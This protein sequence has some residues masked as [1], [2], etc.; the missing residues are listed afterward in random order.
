MIP[1][2]QGLPSLEY[3]RDPYTTMQALALNGTYHLRTD[4][5]L[6]LI[7]D[8]TM[9]TALINHQALSRPSHSG[10]VDHSPIFREHVVPWLRR[11][12]SSG[13]NVLL[14]EL[15][16]QIMDQRLDLLERKDEV[17]IVS[18]F[19]AWVP[20]ALMCNLLGLLDVDV[21]IVQRLAAAI[22]G[23][24]DL[25]HR[26]SSANVQG[27]ELFLRQ[28]VARRINAP[29]SE[30]SAPLLDGL[31]K[32]WSNYPT[33]TTESLVI[34]CARLLT[35]G[36]S[37]ISGLLGNL[38]DDFFQGHE[39]TNLEFL[40]DAFAISQKQMRICEMIVQMHTPVLVL[41]RDVRHDFIWA[42][43]RF[44]IGQRL[45]LVIPTVILGPRSL[46][47][48]MNEE[49]ISQISEP[50]DSLVARKNLS[51][52]YGDHY[53]L[54]ATLARLQISQLLQRMPRLISQWQ[55]GGETI[56]RPAWVLHEPTHL[57]LTS[58]KV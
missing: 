29:N 26:L 52:G 55:R 37:T 42:G 57:P 24:Y 43:N 30:T 10:L 44:E 48:A 4:R 50:E 36:T 1:F 17:D 13:Q 20:A 7:A 39:A 11:F 6:W 2:G 49:V 15:I 22:Q 51:F 56:W 9:V 23:Q 14:K 21:P 16:A 35:A 53:C 3:A 25:S 45:L 19:A 47:Q 8:P 34:T 54:G 28:L 33:L 12:M 41:K 27:S 32:L 18:D 58:L 5:R 38:L 31:R 40:L 46:S